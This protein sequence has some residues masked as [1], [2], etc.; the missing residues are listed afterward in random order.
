MKKG[1]KFL[2]TLTVAS[3]VFS[4][5]VVSAADGDTS[6]STEVTDPNNAIGNIGGDGQLEGY[7][8]KEVF[9]IVVPTVTDVNFTADPQ[10]LLNIAASADY[11]GGA[12]AVYFANVGDSG[13]TYSDTSDPITV[14]NKSSY[15]VDVNLDVA[16][17]AGDV[18]L[19]EDKD[20]LAAATEPSLYMGV[21]TDSGTAVTIDKASYKT[22]DKKVNGVPEVGGSVTKGYTIKSTTTDPGDGTVASPSGKYYSYGL[23]DDF[24]DDD[25]EKVSYQ[26]KAA[27]DKTADWS[28][29]KQNIDVKVV[30]NCKKHS[31]APVALYGLYYAGD[32]GYLSK[33]DFTEDGGNNA[34]E[35]QRGFENVEKDDIIDFKVNG[36][37]CDFSVTEDGYLLV[38]D[39]QVQEAL[40]D[41]N[42]TWEITFTC[43]GVKYTA[44][45]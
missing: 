26:L 32:G 16:V 38:T 13:T 23:T 39:A 3:M 20:D 45:I 1:K 8:N 7:I 17:T 33:T 10:G 19:V 9:R 27:C 29:V 42:T 44:Q 35:G 4:P 43:D 18:K 5:M 25:A 31:D 2:V 41:A 22:D 28:K 6:T 11:T 34:P 30:W 36:T 15:D 40:G 21:I 24:A 37:A 12:G 14:I